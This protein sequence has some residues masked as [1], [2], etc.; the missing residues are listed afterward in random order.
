M[1]PT[2]TLCANCGA[3]LVGPFC[4]D[5][6]QEA[7]ERPDSLS[8]FLRRGAAELLSLD[9]RVLRSLRD[10]V[11]RPGKLT[12]DYLSGHRIRYA[13]PVQL[14]LLS[15]ALFFLVNSY[16]PFLVVDLEHHRIL[17][18]LGIMSAGGDL[19]EA[20]LQAFASRGIDPR[21]FAERFRT[22]AGSLL[23]LLLL[24]V[25]ILFGLTIAGFHP[26]APRP[27][28]RAG[29]FALHWT[30]FYLLLMILER[31]PGGLPGS[32]PVV[33]GVLMV[34]ALCHL[35]LSLRRVYGQ[36]WGVSIVKGAGLFFTLN[37]F[38]G[39]WVVAVILYAFSHV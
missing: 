22:A 12:A 3:R 33:S 26:R 31:L 5:C 19:S 6:G 15:A 18:A 16:H 37:V 32:R 13:Q 14:Y 9:G 38:L 1:E 36:S 27:M 17:S 21:L 29:V 8:D 7:T 28:L 2:S 20:R 24:A 25:V 39:F 11:V 34:A 23:P 10:L 30:G 35:V 4:H